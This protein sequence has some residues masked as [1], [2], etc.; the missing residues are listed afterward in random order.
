MKLELKNKHFKL[1]NNV[2]HYYA[3]VIKDN[4]LI[5]VEISKKQYNRAEIGHKIEIIRDCTFT[6]IESYKE[7]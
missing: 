3:Q 6:I 1:H 7:E 2:K 5:E 4:K